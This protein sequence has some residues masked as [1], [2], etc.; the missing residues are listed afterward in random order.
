MINVLHIDTELTWRGGENQ[1]R[2]LIENTKDKS[3]KHFVACDPRSV[4]AKKF[5]KICDTVFFKF[6]GIRA[7]KSAIELSKWTKENGFSFC[8]PKL[9]ANI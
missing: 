9:N 8:Q 3:I 2:L 6:K 1:V 4:G 5:P 7:F